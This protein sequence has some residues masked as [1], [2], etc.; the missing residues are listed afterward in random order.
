MFQ[1]IEEVA[2][3]D[4]AAGRNLQLALSANPFLTWLPEEGAAETMNSHPDT[5]IEGSFTLGPRAIPVDGGYRLSG[6][7]LFVS[8]GDNCHWFGFLPQLMDRNRPRFHDQGKP[9]PAFHVSPG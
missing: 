4:S 2:R 9:C 8:G 3:H 5:I 7:W 6:Q 1:V